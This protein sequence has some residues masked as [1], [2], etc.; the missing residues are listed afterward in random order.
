M[1]IKEYAMNFLSRKFVFSLTV[2]MLVSSILFA[3]KID[4][5][6]YKDIVIT[7][8]MAYLGSNVASKFVGEKYKAAVDDTSKETADEDAPVVERETSQDEPIYFPHKS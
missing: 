8:S 2:I 7:I 5:T 1:S 6:V 4:S 3:N